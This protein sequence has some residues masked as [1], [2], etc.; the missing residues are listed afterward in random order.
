MRSVPEWAL[1][2]RGIG[3]W[4]GLLRV[5]VGAVGGVALIGWL[6]LVGVLLIPLLVPLVWVIEAVALRV[7]SSRGR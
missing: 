5:A 7:S 1:P 3:F 4:R 2:I 6:G